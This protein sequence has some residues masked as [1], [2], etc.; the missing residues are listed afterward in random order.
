MDVQ[1]KIL[2]IKPERNKDTF[3][4]VSS[5]GEGY[6]RSHYY[7]TKTRVIEYLKS[8]GTIVKGQVHLYD[9]AVFHMNGITAKLN[10][11]PKFF[12]GLE[13]FGDEKT[14]ESEVEKIIAAVPELIEIK[15]ETVASR[16]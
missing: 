7:E 11:H 1:S 6:V 14:L 12:E 5:G 10:L 9:A 2:G 4:S 16:N 8:N 15:N 3:D 13:L